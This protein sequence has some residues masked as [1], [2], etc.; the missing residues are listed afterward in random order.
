MGR[1]PSG[2]APIQSISLIRGKHLEIMRRLIAGESQ[3]R[4]ALEL[5]MSEGR[6]SV[7]CNSP[8]FKRKYAELESE[9]KSRFV[10]KTASITAKVNE[11]QPQAVQVLENI[12]KNKVVDD[13][14]V[15][16]ALKRDVALDVLDLGGNGKKSKDSN[17]KEDAMSAV[18]K[19]IS[20]GF[21]LA[22]A[23]ME[24]RSR[25]DEVVDPGAI[26]DVS[27][28]CG[29]ITDDNTTAEITPV[30]LEST[31]DVEEIETKEETEL[32]RA[33]AKAI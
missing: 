29:E 21:Q 15:S 33:F 10:E 6:L 17:T 27:D 19:I 28:V 20:D 7:V 23:A 5:G 4:I 14:R 32:D 22:K 13:Q 24:E 31:I 8:L 30:T 16:L 9:V 3:R 26:I 18:V 25:R 12:L 2:R 11:L 1:T